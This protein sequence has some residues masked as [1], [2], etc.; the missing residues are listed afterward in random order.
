MV[1][2]APRVWEALHLTAPGHVLPNH[3][4]NSYTLAL[5]KVPN[6]SERLLQAFDALPPKR[7][8]AVVLPDGDDPSIFLGY[9]VSYFAWPREV[10]SVPV[11]RANATRRLQALDRASLAAI[12]F[13]GIDP[14]AAMQ[15]VMQIGSG[16]VM[17]PTAAPEAGIP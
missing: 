7:P 8:I 11:T 2:G 9:L 5:L 3:T 16:L 12:F 13:C 14:P 1:V 4:T 17:I 6:G 10:H 15:P